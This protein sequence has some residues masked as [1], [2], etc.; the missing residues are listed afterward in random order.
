LEAAHGEVDAQNLGTLL[1]TNETDGFDSTGVV[2]SR[3]PNRPG[4][5]VT[6]VFENGD[7]LISAWLRVADPF[8]PVAKQPDHADERICR[9]GLVMVACQK[10][11]E[12]RYWF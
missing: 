3:Q 11:V 8:P 1:L 9:G 2:G 5:T 6:D 4:F 7:R 12:E 10:S